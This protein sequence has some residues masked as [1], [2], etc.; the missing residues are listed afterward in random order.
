MSELALYDMKNDPYEKNNVI[1]KHPELVAQLM[2]FARSHNQ[3][4]YPDRF[5]IDERIKNK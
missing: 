1:D 2:K 3:K 4:F 5:A